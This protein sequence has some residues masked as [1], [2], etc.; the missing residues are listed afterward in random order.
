M[1][2]DFLAAL[3]ELASE[4]DRVVLLTGDLGFT[5]LEPF[6]DRFPDRFFNVGV[7]EQ[8]MLGVATGLA[9]SGFRPYVYSIAT[10]A[11][12]RPYEFIRNG[13]IVHHLPVRVVGI[14]AGFDYGH[15]GV[16]H[17]ALEDVAVMRAQPG[18]TVVAPADG[19]QARAAVRATA[20]LDGPVYYRIGKGASSL[21]ELEGRFRLGH[22]EVVGRPDDV[23]FVALGSMSSVALDAARL[24]SDQGLSAAVAVVSSFNPSPTDDLKELLARVPLAVSVEAHYVNGGV[25][26]FVAEV[27][28][29]NGLGTKLLRRAVERTPTGETGEVAYLLEQHGLSAPQLADGA[30]RALDLAGR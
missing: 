15:N 17:F 3:L 28:A 24:L 11:T 9:E 30:V 22:A 20:E 12:L 6:A 16:S 18:M 13:P 10:F 21:A 2:N 7:A 1:R 25:G 5:V 26:S 8:N 4:D 23:V 27:I 14:G 29:E 19:R